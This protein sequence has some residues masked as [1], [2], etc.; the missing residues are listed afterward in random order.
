MIGKVTAIQDDRKAVFVQLENPADFK[1]GEIVSITK[2]HKKRTPPQNRFYWAFIT[3]CIHP[4]GGNLIEQGHFSKDALHSDIKEWFESTH[5]HDFDIG[6]KFSTTDF[7]TK[8]FSQFFD[9]VERELMNG[10][11]EINTSPFHDDYEK[12]TGW[13]DYSK[14]DFG[15]YLDEKLPF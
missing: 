3:W 5:K 8:Q 6:K 15:E 2:A 4:R 14:A 13:S 9:I 1:M 7:D 10:F 12:Y 11:F